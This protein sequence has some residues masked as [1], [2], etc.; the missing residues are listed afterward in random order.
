MK[1]RKDFEK[2]RKVTMEQFGINL[3]ADHVNFLKRRYPSMGAGIR[4]LINKEIEN[5]RRTTQ[6]T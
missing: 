2:R 3:E 4:E 5:E 1:Q 6:E